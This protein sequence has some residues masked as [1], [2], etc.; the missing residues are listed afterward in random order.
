[1]KNLAFIFMLLLPILGMAQKSTKEAKKSERHEKLMA[2]ID[3]QEWVLK[4]NT[5]RDRY[6]NNVFVN[7]NTNFLAIA[8]SS[9]VVQIAINNSRM[10][11]N[12]LGGETV[13]GRMTQYKVKDFG[14]GKGATIQLTL[15]GQTTL[16]LILNLSDSGFGTMQLSGLFGQR[17]T[18]S[19]EI[20]PLEGSD[21]FVGTTT[22]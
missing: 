2:L 17:L 11:R 10:G 13:D 6:G 3:S 1:M 9:A 16:H 19:G 5:L 21:I 7:E 20:S 15:F 12:G 8:D 4:A 14:P 22:F 18:F